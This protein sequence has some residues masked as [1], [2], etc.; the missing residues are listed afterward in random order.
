LLAAA[1][2]VAGAAVFAALPAT[3]DRFDDSRVASAPR[4]IFEVMVR[5]PIGTALCEELLFR[6]ALLTCFERRHREPVAVAMTA[7]LFGLWHVL[8][9]IDGIE[10]APEP[11]RGAVR[12]AAIARTVA[13]TTAAGVA[14]GYARRRSGS[15]LTPVIVHTAI[16][17]AG[18]IAVRSRRRRAAVPA[19]I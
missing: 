8:P 7:A 17:A 16:N 2:I 11:V 19:R 5:I 12:A 18:F 10:A 6:S 1:P 9:T 3:R 14:F 4:P 15:V 13:A